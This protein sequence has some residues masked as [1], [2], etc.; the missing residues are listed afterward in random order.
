VIGS[1][2]GGQ[3]ITVLYATQVYAGLVWLQIE[4]SDG[5]IGWIPQI[6]VLENTPAPTPSLTRTPVLSVTP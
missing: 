2:Y 4:D 6:Y 1:L 3:K 5:R